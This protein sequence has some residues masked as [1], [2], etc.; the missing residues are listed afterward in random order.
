MCLNMCQWARSL[1]DEL[2]K[3]PTGLEPQSGLLKVSA[4]FKP[5]SGLLKVSDGLEPKF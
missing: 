1:N 5:Q 4:R 3:V 2:L